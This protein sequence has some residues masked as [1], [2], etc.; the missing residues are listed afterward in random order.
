MPQTGW[1]E[2]HVRMPWLRYSTEPSAFRA[3]SP[4]VRIPAALALLVL[5]WAVASRDGG[6]SNVEMLGLAAVHS[7]APKFEAA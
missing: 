4:G 7:F 2:A 5:S 6:V 1:I 3:T